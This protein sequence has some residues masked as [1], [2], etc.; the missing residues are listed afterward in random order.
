MRRGQD[1]LAARRRAVGHTQESLAE[2]LDVAVSTVA[3]WE[4]GA[5]CPLPALRRPLAEALSVSLEDLDRLLSGE[6]TAP[7]G[8]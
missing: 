3:R 2:V 1:K 8:A 6:T 7:E 4:Q 5:G